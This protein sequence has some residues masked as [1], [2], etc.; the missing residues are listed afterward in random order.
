MIDKRDPTPVYFQ[1]A[2]AIKNELGTKYKHGQRLP[3]ENELAAYYK[4]SR[5][6]I[7]NALSNLKAHNLIYTL[8]G[9]ET[10]AAPSGIEGM[11]GFASF[12]AKCALRGIKA[13]S[14]VLGHQIVKNL[15]EIFIKKLQL[16]DPPQQQDGF[17]N[18]K[19]LRKADSYPALIEN[20]FLPLDIFPGLDRIDFSENSL[21]EVFMNTYQVYPTWVDHIVNAKMLDEK[22]CKL[23]L[24]SRP[25]PVVTTWKIIHSEANYPVEYIQSVYNDGYT[26]HLSNY[27]MD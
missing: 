27:R 20:S 23:F 3:S 15:P 6:T 17:L 9:K 4:V 24:H 25:I 12:T 18:L 22:E 7:R 5:V 1:I 26:F 16:A 2:R 14:E 13:E 11:G 21:F 19:R 10:F 8:H